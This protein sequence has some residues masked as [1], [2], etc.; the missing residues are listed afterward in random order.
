MSI[1]DELKSGITITFIA[2]YSNIIIQIIIT[3]ILARLLSPEEFGVVAIIM[4]FITF[5]NLLAD[6]GIGPAIIQSK[7]LMNRDHSSIFNF[8]VII[9]LLLSVGFYLFSFF[10]A[11]FYSNNEYTTIGKYLSLSIFFFSIAIV[12]QSLLKKDRRFKELGLI[13]IIAN[14]LIGILTIVLAYLGFSY[15]SLVWQAVLKSVILFIIF[16]KI[17]KLKYQF[18]FSTAPIKNI[19]SFSAYQF[20]FNFINYFSRNLDNILIGK[21]LG[22]SALGYYDKAYKLMLYPVQNLTHVIT[23]VLHPVLSNYQNETDVIYNTYKKVIRI[24][25]ILG[26]PITVFL[27]FAADEVIL[28]FYGSDWLSSIPA[29]KILAITI[30]I[31][32]IL[33]SSGSIFQSVG[34]TDLLFLSGALSAV[35]TIAGICFGI[36]L[37]GSIEWVSIGLLLSFIINFIQCYW[38]MYKYVFKRSLFEFFNILKNPVF[39]GIIMTIGFLFL[40]IDIKNIFM[41]LVYKAFLA[42]VLFLVGSKLIKDPI[43]D[44]LI[45]LYKSKFRLSKKGLGK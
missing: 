15:Y 11:D 42:V 18:V 14:I 30:M 17:S 4:V 3:A 45:N 41:S 43:I 13:E 6:M 29:F 7:S 24:L 28:I 39:V 34:R 5:F 2:R 35:F 37:K 10:I 9:G 19:F 21:F 1:R 8:T 27:F 20:L 25:A 32:I 23:P 12:P 22:A 33:S 31:Q 36:F 44:Y 16:F 26:V 38:L 40:S